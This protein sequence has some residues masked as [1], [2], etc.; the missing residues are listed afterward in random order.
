MVIGTWSADE[1]ARSST[2][3]EPEALQCTGEWSHNQNV[4]HILP[5]GS[6]RYDILCIASDIDSVC[7]QSQFSLDR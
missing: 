1:L 6:F 2:W 7:K 5:F 3:R 4:T